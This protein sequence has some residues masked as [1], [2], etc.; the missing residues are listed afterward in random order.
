MARSAESAQ[1]GRAS[2]ARVELAQESQDEE[3]TEACETNNAENVK[4]PS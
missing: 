3:M 2:P 4:P 1:E